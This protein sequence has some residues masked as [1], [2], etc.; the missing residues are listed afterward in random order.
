MVT[1]GV[2]GAATGVVALAVGLTVVAGWLTVALALAGLTVGWFGLARVGR[3]GG[4]YGSTTAL[5]GAEGDEEAGAVE[6]EEEGREMDGWTA[7]LTVL[8]LLVHPATI[9]RRIARAGRAAWRM[10]RVRDMSALNALSV[11]SC[12]FSGTKCY[13]SHVVSNRPIL[14]CRAG[15]GAGMRPNRDTARRAVTAAL[16]VPNPWQSVPKRNTSLT[17]ENMIFG[18]TPERCDPRVP[19]FPR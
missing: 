12:P 14:H 4:R 8:A 19:L 6:D 15:A 7:G 10:S 2:D 13:M 17:S 3:L 16:S 18:N 11:L 5:T 9:P 1:R